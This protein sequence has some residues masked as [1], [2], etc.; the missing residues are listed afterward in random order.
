VVPVVLLRDFLQPVAEGAEALIPEPRTFP[1]NL[2][3]PIH[4]VLAQRVLALLAMAPMAS[5]P[6][7]WIQHNIVPAVDPVDR[8]ERLITFQLRV[9]WSY[10]PAVS[11]N[12]YTMEDRVVQEMPM[13]CPE[14][15]AEEVPAST[16]TEMPHPLMEVQP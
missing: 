7:L 16:R 10:K 3:N 12:S 14:G 8:P 13:G 6:G 4:T 9:E 1:F 2:V 15:V 5:E 11:G